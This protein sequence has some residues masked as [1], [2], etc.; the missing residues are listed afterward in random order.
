MPMNRVSQ[1]SMPERAQLPKIASVVFVV[2]PHPFEDVH[3]GITKFL[4]DAPLKGG[5]I[6]KRL[7]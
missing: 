7:Y 3:V 5:G 2:S 4:R 1:L 6:K